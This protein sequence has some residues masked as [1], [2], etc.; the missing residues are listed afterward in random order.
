MWESVR[1]S[2]RGGPTGPPRYRGPRG[3]AMPTFVWR[4]CFGAT[5][6]STSTYPTGPG[7]ARR[8]GFGKKG[9]LISSHLSVVKNDLHMAVPCASRLPAVVGASGGTLHAT[10]HDARR[11]ARG[12]NSAPVGTRGPS[13]HHRCPGKR[14]NS[15]VGSPGGA[16]Q[17]RRAGRLRALRIALGGDGCGT[18]DARAHERVLRER[19]YSSHFARAYGTQCISV[20]AR[21]DQELVAVLQVH[22]ALRIGPEVPRQT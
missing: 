8:E 7:T 22:P 21:R 14:R 4:P 9:R 19:P 6:P 1:G 15:R 16:G 2:P 18:E 10:D 11:P 3:H 17:E 20:F 13:P 12:R 5:A